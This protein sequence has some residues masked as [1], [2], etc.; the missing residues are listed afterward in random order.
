MFAACI[1]LTQAPNLPAT[2]LAVGCYYEMFSGC[3]FAMSD[4]G[5]TF[6]FEFGATPP[7]TVGLTTYNTYYDIA[8]WMGN[9][10]SLYPTYTI[11]IDNSQSGQNIV[12]EHSDTQSAVQDGWVGNIYINAGEVLSFRP[13][14]IDDGGTTKYLAI[15]GVIGTSYTVTTDATLV[16]TFE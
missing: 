10:N 11:R 4:D 9:T 16:I 14:S 12:F 13:A 8:D 2:T 6:N 3:T 1:G 15:N 7:V 5:T